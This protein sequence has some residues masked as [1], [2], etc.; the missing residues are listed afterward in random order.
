MRRHSPRLGSLLH[1]TLLSIDEGIAHEACEHVLDL[2]IC[3]CN[4]LVRNGAC[5]ENKS[6]REIKRQ[7]DRRIWDRLVL[8]CEVEHRGLHSQRVSRLASE[9]SRKF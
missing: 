2:S 8:G 9:M 1:Q 4:Q 6:G 5:K 7:E 3:Q